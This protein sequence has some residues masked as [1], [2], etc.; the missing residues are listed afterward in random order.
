MARSSMAYLITLLRAKVNDTGSDI[1]T[2]DELQKYLDMHRTHILRERLRNDVDEL[3]YYSAFG[4]LEGTYSLSTEDDA[5]WDGDNT[6]IKMWDSPNSSASEITPDSWNLVSGDFGFDD[7]QNDRYY[8]DAISYK[9]PGA[10]AEC[11]EQLAMDPK[12]AWEWSRGAK[13]SSFTQYDLLSLAKYH[14]SL[15]GLKST[16]VGRTYRTK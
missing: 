1:W 13:G 10:I 3:I 11:L 15:T 9:L 2:D 8:L 6:I 16:S 7:E 14:R 12:A 5:A 4:L